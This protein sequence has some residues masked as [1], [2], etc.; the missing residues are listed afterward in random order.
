MEVQLIKD[1]KTA[2]LFGASG[3]VGGYCLQFLLASPV[4][5][6]VKI[7]VRKEL[8]FDNE[9]LEQHVIDFDN[10]EDY[11]DLIKGD[12]VFC[13][14]GTTIKKAGDKEAFRKI[15]Y[16]YSF[17]I[18]KISKEQRANQLLLVSSVGA[19]EDSIF[20]YSRIKG[21]LENAIK[22]MNFWATHIFQPSVLLGKRN[23]N[24]WGEQ[25]AGRLAKGFDFL[26]GGLLTKYSPVEAELVAKAM[27]IAAQ[28][29]DNGL[30][31]Y[32]SHVL[33]KMV[34]KEEGLRL[35]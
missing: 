22:K 15:D 20:F 26:T 14:L 2:L 32:P 21:E 13:C 35:L 30:Q 4:Y 19:D 27:V 29:F 23:E 10:I 6:K 33:Q 28:G 11:K 3:L 5:K 17:Q 16:T 18:A 12:D 1:D 7:F 8:D 25:L 34:K 24:R 9:K 31:I